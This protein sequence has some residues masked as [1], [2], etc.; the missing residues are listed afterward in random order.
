MYKS[1]EKIESN[2]DTTDENNKNSEVENLEILT[3]KSQFSKFKKEEK[4]SRISKLRNEFVMLDSEIRKKQ[5][6]IE[7][8]DKNLEEDIK[9]VCILEDKLS[10]K[11]KEKLVDD[12]KDNLQN[13]IMKKM[14]FK[15]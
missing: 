10:A 15:K 13:K 1:S 14:F 4:R 5:E 9:W 2:I 3:G 12:K 7:S 8:Y 11:L 6:A